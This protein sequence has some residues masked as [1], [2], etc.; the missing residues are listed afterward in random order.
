MP[1]P[2]K[3][4]LPCQPRVVALLL[5][6]L[7]EQAGHMP[8][9][10]RLNQLFAADPVLAAWLLGHANSGVY[11]LTGT[12][13]SVAQAVALLGVSQLRILVRKAQISL[14]GRVQG[15]DRLAALSQA[16]ARLARSLANLLALDAGTAHAAGL[17]HGLGQM[18]LHQRQ[19]QQMQRLTDILPVWDPRRP[20][21]EQQELGY[22]S[23]QTGAMLLRDWGVPAPVWQP[24]RDMEQPLNHA[25]F[26]PLVAVLH[27]AVWV[28][29]ARISGWAQRDLVAGFPL[30]VAAA[31]GLDMDVV[32]QQDAPDWSK[33]IY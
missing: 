33:S 12:I 8:S 4:S 3:I 17:L 28:Q 14:T 29:R 21:L 25:D 31:V 26:E 20:L 18:A 6:E 2:E 19:P 30:E 15:M 10:R 32:L 9:L 11:Q 13:T 27:L 5:N 16:S 22:M 7:P 23:N 24:I 1:I